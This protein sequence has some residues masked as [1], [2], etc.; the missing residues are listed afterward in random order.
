MP[1]PPLPIYIDIDGTL[2]TTPYTK[3]GEVIL[4]RINAVKDLINA[5]QEVVLWSGNGTEYA[6]EFATRHGLCA[7]CIGKPDYCIDDNPKIRSGFDGR[8]FSPKRLDE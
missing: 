6:K 7:V 4:T 3:D 5:G 1:S 8:I 2:T